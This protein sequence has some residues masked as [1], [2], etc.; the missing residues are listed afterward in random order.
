MSQSIFQIFEM[1][2]DIDCM[3]YFVLKLQVV[4]ILILCFSFPVKV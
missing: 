2:S 1:G 3:D 4:L